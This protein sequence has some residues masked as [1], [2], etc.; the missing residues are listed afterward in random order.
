MNIVFSKQPIRA[1][2]VVDCLYR[3][4]SLIREWY[5]N[6]VAETKVRLPGGRA[7]SHRLIK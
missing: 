6:E 3:P 4:V 1:L 5:A 7:R 2:A